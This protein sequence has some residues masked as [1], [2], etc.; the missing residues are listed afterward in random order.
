[1]THLNIKWKEWA[2]KHRKSQGKIDMFYFILLLIILEKLLGS[3]KAVSKELP[4][5]RT[6][7][8]IISRLLT[9]CTLGAPVSFYFNLHKYYSK[10]LNLTLCITKRSQVWKYYLYF[11]LCNFIKYTFFSFRKC[12]FKRAALWKEPHNRSS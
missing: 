1:M 8:S 3:V 4:S 12:S 11:F 10:C 6:D 5:P 9:I 7:L 2:W